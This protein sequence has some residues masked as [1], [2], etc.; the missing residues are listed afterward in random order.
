MPAIPISRVNNNAWGVGD[1]M[2]G[3][4]GSVAEYETCSKSFTDL[5]G[6]NEGTLTNFHPGL[7]NLVVDYPHFDPVLERYTDPG[8]GAFSDYS[9][10]A[11]R[12]D[13]KL[14]AGQELFVSY[15]ERW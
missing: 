15:G 5:L 6:A 10:M 4:E 11:Y 9:G 14:Q 13:E 1:Y 3:S 8:A 2:W 7:V 12:S